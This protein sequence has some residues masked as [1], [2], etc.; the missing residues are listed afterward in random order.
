[1]DAEERRT[2]I[3]N[4]AIA[5]VIGLGVFLVIRGRIK[6]EA[7]V[8]IREIDLGIYRFQ[9]ESLLENPDWSI[10]WN[11]GDELIRLRRFPKEI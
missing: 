6:K 8:E 2:K 4:I 7:L 10:V 3:R 9:L 11:H 1:M 5:G